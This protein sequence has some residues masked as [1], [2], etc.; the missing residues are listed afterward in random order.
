MNK[1]SKN[2]LLGELRQM[3]SELFR[4]HRDGAA[5]TRLARAHGYVDG[6]MRS[7]VASGLVTQ[8]ELLALVSEQR[9]QVLG[10]AV[11]TVVAESEAA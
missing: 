3:L 2:E 9:K 7:A 6:Y 1:M 10:P 5:G 4:Q 11:G 8:R